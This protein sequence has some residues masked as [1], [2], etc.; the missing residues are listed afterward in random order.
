MCAR[1]ELVA[2]WE[3]NKQTQSHG[4]TIHRSTQPNE[5]KELTKRLY[6]T[7]WSN[8]SR[9]RSNGLA[10]FKVKTR[11][12]R[13]QC[14]NSKCSDAYPLEKG[15]IFAKQSVVQHG[16][17]PFRPCCVQVWFI[18][19]KCPYFRFHCILRFRGILV[20]FYY[21]LTA[22]GK[23]MSQGKKTKNFWIFPWSWLFS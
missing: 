11:F 6:L 13:H 4:S 14:L 5:P 20:C 15:H 10:P 16:D 19:F 22:G 23:Q 9:I 12:V 21:W 17:H 18:Q 7:Y 2:C 3:G 8:I 1:D